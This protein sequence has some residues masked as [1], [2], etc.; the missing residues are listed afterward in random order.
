M[1]DLEALTA[2]VGLD[3]V[4]TDAMFV[5]ARLWH[6]R[7][8]PVWASLGDGP[9]TYADVDTPPYGAGLLPMPGREGR[10]RNRVTTRVGGS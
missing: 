4:L 2:G 5:A 1:R 7:G 8:G 3:A 6:E 9:L 10:R